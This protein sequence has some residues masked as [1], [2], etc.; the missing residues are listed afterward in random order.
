MILFSIG[1]RGFI[2]GWKGREGRQ[3][4]D[5]LGLEG[6]WIL[7]DLGSWNGLMI[8]LPPIS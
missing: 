5:G 1:R 8:T 2:D 7:I 4:M 3:K 6:V